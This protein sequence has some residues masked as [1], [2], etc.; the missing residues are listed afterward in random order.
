MAFHEY[1]RQIMRMGLN[2][3]AYRDL[4]L[5][6]LRYDGLPYPISEVFNMCSHKSRTPLKPFSVSESFNSAVSYLG[7]FLN[8]RGL[9]FDYINSFQD[10]KEEL[11][12]KLQKNNI[13]TIAII[14]T[15]Y[16]SVFPILEIIEFIKKY[17]RTARIIIGGPF[18]ST[19]F[20]NQDIDSLEYLLTTTLGADI[21]VNS[22]QG[23]ETLVNT[24]E[25]LKANLPLKRIN[26]LYYEEGDSYIQTPVKKENNRL[27][28][29]M[30]N[31]DLFSHRVGEFVNVRTSISC[32]YSCGFCGFPQHAGEYQVTGVKAIERE[33]SALAK[34]KSVKSVHFIDDTFN[35][36]PGRFKSILQM[37][38]KNNFDFHWHS[39][40]R[41]QYADKET[42]KLM[43]QSRCDGVFLGIES[44]DDQI[45]KNMNKE[46]NTMKY[47]EG[48]ELLK[49][50]DITTFGNFIIGYPGETPE[51]VQ[52]TI[53]FIE[54]SQLDFYRVQLW[55]CEPITPIYR[56]RE[57]YNLMGESFE[58]SHSTMNSTEASNFVKE[59]FLTRRQ[60]VWVPQY[61]FDFDSL[62][63]LFHRGMT[64]DKVKKFL[65]LFNDG[66][67]EKLTHPSLKEASYLIFKQILEVF[68][69]APG[70]NPAEHPPN[71]PYQV[72]NSAAEFDL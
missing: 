34:I 70:I 7:S 27:E 65:E 54:R 50:Y 67:R 29:N 43:K 51:S 55:Y 44:G 16:V 25:A 14:T 17:N 19:Q 49:E 37:M 38:I 23:E 3:G 10:E 63:H 71:R 52:H 5:N 40:F 41:C 20:R 24:I 72:D 46:A 11:A 58:W 35:V 9:T 56:Q 18:I 36:P 48:I 28:E 8:R 6:F 33:L 45:L 4:D 31:W 68:D 21:Y 69:P 2:S 1:E 12:E 59:I 47:L 61:N 57:K 66:V 42:V 53:E 26:N 15:L 30:V 13:V 62:W 22:S 32:P 64:L 39:Y 60:P